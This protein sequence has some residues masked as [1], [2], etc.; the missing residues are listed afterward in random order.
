MPTELLRFSSIVPA[1]TLLKLEAV[2]AR[3]GH[4]RSHIVQVLIE[5]M[6]SVTD[7]AKRIAED[8]TLATCGQRREMGRHRKT[9]NEEEGRI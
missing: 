1:A 4:A 8:E 3:L 2:A 9:D 5:D 6:P 7:L